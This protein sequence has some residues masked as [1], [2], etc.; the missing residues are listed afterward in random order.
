MWLPIQAQEDVAGCAGTQL[1]LAEL[2]RPARQAEWT[3]AGSLVGFS[4]I[5]SYSE[6]LGGKEQ[7]FH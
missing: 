6:D 7:T 2:G 5:K 3:V 1:S 4:H